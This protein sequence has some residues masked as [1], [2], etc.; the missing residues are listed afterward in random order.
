M[1]VSAG[2]ELPAGALVLRLPS[3]AHIRISGQQRQPTPEAFALSSAERATLATGERVL[4]SVWDRAR[5]T[6]AEARS[7]RV[8]RDVTAFELA[9]TDVRAIAVDLNHSELSVIEDP[10]HAPAAATPA[11]RDAHAGIAGLDVAPVGH[12]NPRLLKDVRDALARA[13]RGPVEG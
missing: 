10:A 5:I 11:Q 13:C 9:V 6:V 2:D 3:V 4:V 8:G 7:L 12:V 1:N